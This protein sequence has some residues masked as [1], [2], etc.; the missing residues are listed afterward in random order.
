MENHLQ[1]N[2]LYRPREVAENGWILNTK[3]K[4]DYFYVLKQIRRGNLNAY[5]AGK[6][7]YLVRGED[8]LDYKRKFEGY[9]EN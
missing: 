1:E 4:K 6:K 3:R 8:I 7:G 2:E 5:P 9:S